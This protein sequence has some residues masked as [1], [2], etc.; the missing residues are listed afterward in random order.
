MSS[1]PVISI[2]AKKRGTTRFLTGST[3]KHL[4]RVE[5]LADLARAEVGGDRGAGHA[6]HDHRVDPGRELADRGQDEEAAEAVERAE[7]G[8]EVGR[9]HARGAVAEGD[10]RDQERE[11][12]KAQRE[13]EL[14]H[15][16]A[17]VGVG[18]ADRRDDRLAG[19]DHHVPDLLEEVLG[20]QE[21]PVGGGADH[22]P[23]LRPRC[24][25]SYGH[26][27]EIFTRHQP[28]S[29][30]TGRAAASSGSTCSRARRCRRSRRAPTCELAGSAISASIC[31]RFSCS[32][33]APLAERV[34]DRPRRGRPARRAA[35][36]GRRRRARAGRRRAS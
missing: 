3:P 22:L 13:Q 23:L 19:Q 12:A 2:S 20:G 33:L 28:I 31:S 5:L 30:P 16:L 10:R 8:E 1:R 32:T 15:E 4:E 27:D 36:R 14:R 7:E 11:P 9:L 18:R 24:R 25:H 17:A 34:A 35:P 26:P 21:G 29:I 6:G